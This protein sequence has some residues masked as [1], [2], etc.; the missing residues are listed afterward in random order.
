M[1]GVESA[2]GRV[3][4]AC[5]WELTLKCNLHCMHCGSLA[6]RARPS[7]LPPGDCFAIVD[8]LA[9]LACATLTFIGG[10]VFLYSGWE[11]IARYASERGLLVNI[12]TSAYGFGEAELE[13]VQHA[14]LSNVG[15]SIDGMEES[16]TRIRRRTDSFAHAVRALDL[17]SRE[18][19][20][21]A[22]VTSVLQWN[23]TDLEPLYEL[24][25]GHGVQLWQI[26][27]VNPMGSMAGKQNLV[28]DPAQITWLIEFI[29]EKSSER[30]M[31]VVAADSVGYYFEDTEGYIRGRRKP[32]CVWEGCQAGMTSVFIDSAGNVKGCGSLYDDAFIEGNVKER[33]LAEIWRDERLFS[34]NRAF[35]R[36]LL[37]GRCRGC[38]VAEVCM[39][40]C[41]SSNYFTT[42]SLYENAFCSHNGTPRDFR[43]ASRGAFPVL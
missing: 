11:R 35:H 32:I 21:T 4:C 37:K 12:M 15:V 25:L 28:L 30:K 16:H 5:L 39:G 40:G 2:R 17:L 19:I 41:R 23:F 24:L 31:I 9:D 36:R 22:V 27:L 1:N 38:D 7:E 10:E 8:E 34:Y 18:G 42:G 20:A 6:G 14:R 29:R 43:A 26:Q 13:Q 3:L 33:R